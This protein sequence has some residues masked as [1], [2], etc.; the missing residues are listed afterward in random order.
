[1][2]KTN[3]RTLSDELINIIRARTPGKEKAGHFLTDILPI[4]KEA[5]YRRLRGEIAFTL[6]EAATICKKLNISLDLLMGIRQENIY[7]FHLNI[8]SGDP[9]Q[10][11]YESLLNI[12]RSMS[13]IT[14]GSDV[15]LYR[16]HRT[17]PQEFL[18]NYKFLSRV[19][20]YILYYQLSPDSITPQ[21]V[22]SFAELHIPEELVQAQQ[23]ATS[24]IQGYNSSL[25]LDKRIFI[26]YIE[27]VNYFHMLGLITRADIDKIKGELMLVIDDMERCAV[28]GLSLEGKK[29]DIYLSHISFDCSYSFMESP[30]FSVSSLGVFCVNYLAGQNAKVNGIQKDWI[31]SL[32]RFSSG[33]SVSDELKRRE[34][35]RTQRDYVETMLLRSEM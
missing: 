16:A 2:H 5:A 28:T 10:N 7:A 26:D 33:I 13:Y 23:Q 8:T 3:V 35:F 11:Y 12:N 32:M 4:G 21:P 25:I 30:G 24:N 22:K 15:C 14:D 17:L 29:M 18:Y 20:T 1:M 19:Y 27:I 31:K 34:F 9:I 6:E